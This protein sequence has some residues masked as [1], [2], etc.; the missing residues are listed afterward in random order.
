M[1][2]CLVELRSRL[3]GEIRQISRVEP[4]SREPRPVL[5]HADADLDRVP[6]AFWGVERIDQQDAVVGHRPGER[7]ERF[8]LVAE[9]QHPTVAVRSAHRDA[10]QLAGQHVRGGRAASDICGPAGAEPPVDSL[11]PAQ[12]EFQHGIV[13]RR[14]AHAGGLGRHQRL[15]VD[16]VEQGRLDDLALQQRAANPEQRL[17]GKN[18]R[19][20]GD[21]I[22]VA[23]ELQSTEIVQERCIEQG[24]APSALETR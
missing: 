11:C 20:L 2:P 5:A 15:E 8:A 21:R 13:P 6:H 10:M 24:R 3:D 23:G 19:A 14:Q 12:P 4:D 9:R 7:L 1:Q 16:D 22:H 18:D 17:V